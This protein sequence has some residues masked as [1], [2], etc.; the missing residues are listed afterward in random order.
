MAAIARVKLKWTGF[1]G[2][3]GFSVF[4]FADFN[5]QDAAAWT[6]ADADLAADR[7]EA[8]AD[9]IR[10]V[11]AAPVRLKVESDVEIIERETGQLATVVSAGIRAEMANPVTTGNYS[12]P[13]GAVIN[14]RT[15]G[16]RNGRRVRGR[17]FVVPCYSAAYEANGSLTPEA[18]LQLEGSSQELIN[19][20]GTPD[21]GVYARPT[22][23]G[24]TDGVWY[25]ATSMSVPDM[26]AVLRSRR[27]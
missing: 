13:T 7:I 9:G 3:P 19:A 23:P 8:W 22:G 14:W 12:G 16:V 17:T 6:N 2:A 20:A 25:V 26:A 10:R 11:C 4:H 27:D 18:R 21:I 24:A 5:L 15:A 1:N